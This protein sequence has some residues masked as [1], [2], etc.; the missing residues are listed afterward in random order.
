VALE[1]KRATT[2]WTDYGLGEFGLFYLRN[3]EQEEVD[4]L[5]TRDNDP[6]F[7][8]E[9]KTG[10]ETPASSLKKFQ[11]VLHVPAVQ[12]VRRSGVSHAFHN[13]PDRILVISASAWL[14]NLA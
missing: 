11:T 7:L 2:N 4:F 12:L 8:V 1:L 14:P 5:V 10:E 6:L 13:G 9:A 3:K